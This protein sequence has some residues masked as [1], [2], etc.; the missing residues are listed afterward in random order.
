MAGPDEKD[1][2]IQAGLVKFYKYE[3]IKGKYGMSDLREVKKQEVF[4]LQRAIFK[5]EQY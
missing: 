2:R 4:S 1:V 3:D 5:E